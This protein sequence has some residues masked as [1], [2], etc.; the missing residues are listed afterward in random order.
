[1][2]IHEVAVYMSAWVGATDTTVTPLCD[3]PSILSYFNQT[4]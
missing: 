1:V 4:G 3:C 2:Q